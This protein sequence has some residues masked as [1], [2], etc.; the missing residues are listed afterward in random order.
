M[1]EE[2]PHTD[3][4][5]TSPNPKPKKRMVKKMILIG[6]CVLVFFVGILLF[7]AFTKSKNKEAI[8]YIKRGDTFQMVI[9]KLVE[10]EAIDN[11][12]SFKSTAKMM[13]FNTSKLKIGKYKIQPRT[14]NLKIINMLSKGRQVPDK[15]VFKTVRTHE[16]FADFVAEKF[17]IQ[18]DSMLALLQDTTA[19]KK[20]G[21][22]DTSVMA[23]L[24]PDTYEMYWTSS[25]KEVLD[26]LY[27]GY[28]KFW[29]QTRIQKANNLAL[30][31]LEVTTIAS[32]IEAETQKNAEKPTI[33][34]VYL[35]RLNKGM[36]LQA[37]P[38]VVFANQDFTVKR[39][40]G[41]MLK[42]T[43]PYNTYVHVGLPPGPISNPSK[44]SID[45]VLNTQKHD[46]LFF[47]AKEDFSGFHSFAKDFESHKKN[48]KLYQEAL[49]K[50]GIE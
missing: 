25:P 30:T 7:F 27:G 4:Q 40:A 20:Y 23:M 11:V 36:K 31:P 41:E 12:L 45:A 16:D 1:M 29:N 32:I 14:S 39:I 42:N 38:T 37:D 49:N 46:Y 34:G 47:C 2:T 43:S 44:T 15:V 48:A 22:N 18:R 28:Q 19:L 3:V 26:K 5:N 6:V 17:Y 21:V 33:A 10:A 9:D 24:I 35:N 8:I 13:G 50:R